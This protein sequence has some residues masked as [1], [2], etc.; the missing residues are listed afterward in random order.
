MDFLCPKLNAF[1]LAILK[2]S[3]YK[4][5]SLVPLQLP[6]FLEN[7]TQWV[8]KISCSGYII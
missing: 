6:R 4:A 1:S 3:L 5:I 2:Q 8:D 7:G